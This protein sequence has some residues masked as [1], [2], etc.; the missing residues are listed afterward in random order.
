MVEADLWCPLHSGE[1]TVNKDNELSGVIAGDSSWQRGALA[2]ASVFFIA[3]SYHLW[4]EFQTPGMTGTD[5]YWHMKIAQL[6]WTGEN[7]VLG[8][9]FP[10]MQ[11]STYNDL[12][13]DWQL[14][15]HLL[16]IPFTALGLSLGGKVS[17]VFFAALLT[18]SIYAILRHSRTPFAWPLS[19]LFLFASGHLT[20]QLHLPRPTTLTVTLLLWLLHLAVR[21]RLLP[22]FF[23]CLLVMFVYNVPHNV[24]AITGICGLAIIWVDGQ[25]P[26]KLM[27]TL[28]AAIA[29]AIVAHPGFWHWRGSFLGLE[30]ANFMLWQQMSGTIAAARDGF[31]VVHNGET[32]PMRM[33]LELTP[34]S[35]RELRDEFVLPMLMFAVAVVTALRSHRH[36]VATVSAV[37]AAGLY[38]MLF[39][40]HGRFVAYWAPFAWVAAGYGLAAVC[41]TLEEKVH[42]GRMSRSLDV[43]TFAGASAAVV[44]QIG[45]LLAGRDLAS[46][47]TWTPALACGVFIAGRLLLGPAGYL[48]GLL[49]VLSWPSWQ[50]AL[51]ITFLLSLICYVI[52]SAVQSH[53]F[54]SAVLQRSKR[55]ADRYQL[56]AA[57]LQRNTA[58]GETVFHA[59]WVDFAYLFAFNHANYYI[60]GFDPYFMFLHDP[61]EYRE[62]VM[63]R[64]GR[65]SPVDTVALIRKLGAAYALARNGSAL[66]TRLRQSAQ[67]QASYKDKYLTVFKL[68]AP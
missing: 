13:H 8:G 45:W 33:G 56:A 68:D 32:L 10:W 48:M 63:V 36:S 66:D 43:V 21:R 15:Y 42:Y 29:L 14:L 19:L 34:F 6:Y 35:G 30:H 9:S 39:L 51:T 44:I 37:A 62:W 24:L 2:V 17:T 55:I 38:F 23:V 16:L 46:W 3:I 53:Q 61:Q 7:P 1:V 41:P 59:R 64:D 11:H 60:V 52:I 31:Q 12:R 18:A 27:A 5:G 47:V 58:P 50:R 57:W 20:L 22:A 54:G 28:A 25:L 26:T 65:R 40:A 49:R 67:A 4:V